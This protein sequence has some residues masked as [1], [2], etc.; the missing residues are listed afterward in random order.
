MLKRFFL[1]FLII[2]SFSSCTINDNKKIK[3]TTTTWIGYT[4]LLYAKEKNWLETLDIKIINVVSL[5]ENMY[6]YKSGKADVYVGTQYEYNF[7]FNENKELTPIMIF[8]KSNGGDV[9]LSNVSIDELIKT[10]KQIDAYLEIDSINSILLND[11]LKNTN[12][13]NKNINYINENQSNISRLKAV[14]MKNPT[15][16]TT[17]VP[18][19]TILERNSFNELSSTKKNSNL[20]IIDG[21]YTT[22]K[23]LNENKDTFLKLKELLDKAIVNLHNNPKE[24]YETIN[25]YL[26]NNTSYEEFLTSLDDVIW[27]NKDIP[28]NILNKLRDSNFKT[29]DLI[30]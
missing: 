5:S 4:P 8:D 22:E 15:I 2:L 21:M 29:R 19:N 11:F 9:I 25:P 3:I 24:F 30:K 14:D 28:E 23:F 26:K 17:Y 7:L 6:L 12:L 27:L 16:I 20:L 18:Y 1:I 10:N 13:Q